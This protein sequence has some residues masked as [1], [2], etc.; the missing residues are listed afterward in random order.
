ML[1]SFFYLFNYVSVIFWS[2]LNIYFWFILMVLFCN[3]K[4]GVIL[5]L[6]QMC[7][8]FHRIE[9]GLGVLGSN[10]AWILLFSLCFFGLFWWLLIWSS[11]FIN[12]S[13]WV[14]C[15]IMNY[16]DYFVFSVRCNSFCLVGFDLFRDSKGLVFCTMR[17][18]YRISV[19]ISSHSLVDKFLCQFW[20]C[21]KTDGTQ[22]FQ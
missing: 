21:V 20:K 7:V 1:A 19:F 2:W 5:V 14:P 6:F 22:I 12:Y 16:S 15:C 11:L 3:C 10:F 9:I 8:G 4:L 17:Y 18:S 13:L